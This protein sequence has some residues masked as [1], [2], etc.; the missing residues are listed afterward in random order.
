MH[1]NFIEIGTSDFDTLIQTCAE[2]AVGLS[3][4]PILEYLQRL[5]AKPD[6]MRVLAAVSHLDG[7]VDAYHVPPSIIELCGL[8]DWMRGC[9]CI[10]MPHPTATNVLNKIGLDPAHVFQKSRV[11]VFSMKTL[12]SMYAVESCDYLKIDT[13]GHD[14]I[15]LKNY[16]EALK[17]GVSKPAKRICFESNELTPA[18]AVDDIIKQLESIG[19]VLESRAGNTY[20]NYVEPST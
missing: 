3:I 9:N 12:L 2:D 11:P 15:I 20:L 14:T 10:G 6:V 17:E 18:D 5:P 8:P 1:Y 7:L 19:Y 13:E 16:V 4:D